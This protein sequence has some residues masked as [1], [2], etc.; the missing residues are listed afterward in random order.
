MWWSLALAGAPNVEISPTHAVRGVVTV[1]AS[2]DQV[3]AK[4]RDPLWVSRIDNSGT[5]VTLVEQDGVCAILDSV[6]VNAIKTVS[7]RT[8]HCPTA[9]GSRSTLVSSNAF[10]AYLA[11]WTVRPHADGAEL[12]YDLDMKTSLMVPQ[13]VIDRTT[14]KSVESLLGKLQ[15]AFTPAAAPR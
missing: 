12:I 1:P 9:S 5:T 6:S 15:A 14:R 10:D 3:L 13:F 8:R 11:A 4:L 7:Y 2:V